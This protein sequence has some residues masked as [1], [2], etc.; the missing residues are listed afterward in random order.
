MS[1][2]S[3]LSTNKEL[4][5]AFQYV[6]Q[7]SRHVYLTGKAGTGKTTFLHRVRREV[8]KNMAVVAPTGVA[9]VNAGGQTIHSLFQ[10]PF[11]LIRPGQS[12]HHSR[13]LSRVKTDL[14]RAIDLL[15]IDEVSMVRVDVLEAID[16]VLR[17]VRRSGLPFGGVQL[18]LIGDLFQLP[19]VVTD[20]EK[21]ELGSYFPSPYFF[22]SKALREATYVHVELTR[23]YRQEDGRFLKL[24]NRVRNNDLSPEVL[25]ELNARRETD[26]DP[27]TAE[28]YVTLT[29]HNKAANELNEQKLAR[30]T[31]PLHRFRATIRGNFPARMYPNRP[32][33]SFRVGA[34][35]MFN[36]NDTAEHRYY[37]GKIG[38]IVAIQDDDITV[39]CPGD[40]FDITVTPVTWENVEQRAGSEGVED[41]TTGTYVQHP[42]RLAWAITIHKSQGL[43][44]ERVVIDAAAAF[45]HGQ[46]Y[47]ALS[48]CKTLEGIVLHS[49]ITATGVRTDRVV[50]RHSSSRSDRQASA[51]GLAA[52]KR[53]FQRETLV[54]FLRLSALEECLLACERSLLEHERRFQ[55][56]PG[57]AFAMVAEQLREKVLRPSRRLA[58]L[59]DRDYLRTTDVTI[60]AVH[61]QRLR[62]AGVYLTGELRKPLVTSL[63]SFAFLTDN[64]EVRRVFTDQLTTLQRELTAVTACCAYLLE[65]T[66]AVTLLARRTAARLSFAKPEVSRQVMVFPA[67][68]PKAGAHP[69]LYEQLATWRRR[70]AREKGVAAFCIAHNSVLLDI[71]RQRPRTMEE[72]RQVSK[73]GP[74]T[75]ERYGE[76]ILAIV[77]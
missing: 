12:V 32:D 6:S 34:Q 14:L 77:A 57:V 73:V 45:A 24:L 30:L 70:V 11:G 52:D 54:D 7:T 74:I 35:V 22:S 53:T 39:R 5:M 21:K 63:K 17:R 50:K 18:L 28:G 58:A 51:A 48:R 23:V 36:R 1:L 44:F 20:E 16:S 62:A 9:A 60:T 13:K 26:F 40:D 42:L 66:D 29:S 46:V 59:F 55:G 37:N 49:P 69:E 10:L 3:P 2:S 67:H 72:L 8:R 47:V 15:I 64:Q 43:T 65:G 41:K 68:T 33:L 75:C 76:D 4:E 71:A 27:V 61:Q 56:E 31:T 25:T 19:P 38:R